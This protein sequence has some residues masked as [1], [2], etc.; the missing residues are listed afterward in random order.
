MTI[1]MAPASV[2]EHEEGGS[3]VMATQLSQA[4]AILSGLASPRMSGRFPNE[5]T[6]YVQRMRWF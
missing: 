2:H 5:A 6:E 4:Q 1:M 3:D